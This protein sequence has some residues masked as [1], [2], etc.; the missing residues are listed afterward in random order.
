MKAGMPGNV[1]AVSPLCRKIV[2]EIHLVGRAADIRQQRRKPDSP[3]RARF[4][5]PLLRELRL[6]V[7]L[8]CLVDGLRQRQPGRRS[9]GLRI[10]PAARSSAGKKFENDRCLNIS[11]FRVGIR[12]R[13]RG[14]HGM[15][16]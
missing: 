13:N 8:E 12:K 16:T 3:L 7:V 5:G 1:E 15:R 14:R 4:D 11:R 10:R 9:G 2:R 6:Q